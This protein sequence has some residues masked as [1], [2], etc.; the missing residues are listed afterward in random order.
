[1]KRH[2]Y[3]YKGAQ[4]DYETQCAQQY[5]IHKKLQITTLENAFVLPI[6]NWR[7][8]GVGYAKGGVVDKDGNYVRASARFRDLKETK[9]PCVLMGGYDFSKKNIPVIKDDCIYCGEY[10]WHYGHFLCE[11]HAIKYFVY[12]ARFVSV[13]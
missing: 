9:Q 2:F 1:M 7:E 4:S 5:I 13:I 8:A 6:K 10:M 3:L 12:S 11:S